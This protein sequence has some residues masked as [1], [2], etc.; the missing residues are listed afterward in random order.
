MND[1][2]YV[3][4]QSSES[5]CVCMCVGGWGGDWGCKNADTR[6]CKITLLTRGQTLQGYFLPDLLTHSPM[7]TTGYVNTHTQAHFNSYRHTNIY[8]QVYKVYHRTWLIAS[9]Y[10]LLCMCVLLGTL[11]THSLLHLHTFSPSLTHIL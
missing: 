11:D 7:Y 1:L 2:V 5:W 6:S 3:S 4:I 9:T 10:P 8:I